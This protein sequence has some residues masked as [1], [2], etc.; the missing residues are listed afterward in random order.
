MN[1]YISLILYKCISL[2]IHGNA[3]SPYIIYERS[4]LLSR[5]HWAIFMYV[6]VCAFP[7]LFVCSRNLLSANQDGCAAGEYTKGMI[8]MLRREPRGVVVAIVPSNYPLM[9]AVWKVRSKKKEKK[10]RYGGKNGKKNKPV[11]YSEEDLIF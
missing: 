10:K 3:F 6:C 4:I 2:S 7:F 5:R 1:L 8:S 9:M 11:K